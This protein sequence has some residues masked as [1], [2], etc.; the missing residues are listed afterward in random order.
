MFVSRETKHRWIASARLL[1]RETISFMCI[2]GD[3]F[4]VIV[5]PRSRA[6]RTFGNAWLFMSR[7]QQ[8]F[9]A[10]RSHYSVHGQTQPPTP[11]GQRISGEGLATRDRSDA[12]QMGSMAN[13]HCGNISSRKQAA[14]KPTIS[15]NTGDQCFKCGWRSLTAC[16]HLLCQC[17]LTA[18]TVVN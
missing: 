2:V 6:D 10:P 12:C 5:M 11:A 8:K 9:S 4:L 13:G 1:A 18:Y 16:R 7:L 15:R 17:I 3:K 14:T